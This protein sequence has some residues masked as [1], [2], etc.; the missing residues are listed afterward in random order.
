MSIISFIYLGGSYFYLERGSLH[1]AQDGLE[2]AIFLPQPPECCNYRYAPPR[3][4]LSGSFGRY[5]YIHL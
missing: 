5:I 1:V 2:L 4:A 3:P